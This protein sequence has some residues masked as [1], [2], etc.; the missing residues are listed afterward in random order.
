MSSYLADMCLAAKN[1]LGEAIAALG[2]ES[3][4]TRKEFGLYLL[5][6]QSALSVIGQV[7]EGEADPDLEDEAISSCMPRIS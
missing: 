5:R 6:V 7:E 1:E 3:S 2:E 4:P